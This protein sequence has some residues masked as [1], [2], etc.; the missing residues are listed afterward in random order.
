MGLILPVLFLMVTGSL[1][2]FVANTDDPV[3]WVIS[4][5]MSQGKPTSS[6][7]V[8]RGPAMRIMTPIPMSIDAGGASAPTGRAPLR[9][10]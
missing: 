5:A 4:I 3:S 8:V 10:A 6:L 2:V 7:R 1:I 9:R